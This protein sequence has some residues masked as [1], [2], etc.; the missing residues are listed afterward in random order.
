MPSLK[1]LRG[2]FIERHVAKPAPAPTSGISV[3]IHAE[4]GVV[5][6]EHDDHISL[7]ADDQSLLSFEQSELLVE[8][9][10]RL[11]GWTVTNVTRTSGQYPIYI[12][13]TGRHIPV[14]QRNDFAVGGRRAVVKVDKKHIGI[15]TKAKSKA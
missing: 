8:R 2:M 6:I 4:S 7:A 11:A 5:I 12:D 13:Q 3:V 15:G 14:F 10:I 9:A 1:E